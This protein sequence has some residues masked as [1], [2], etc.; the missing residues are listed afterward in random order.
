M[1]VTPRPTRFV[2]QMDLY[3]HACAPDRRTIFL[4]S[5]HAHRVVFSGSVSRQGDSHVGLVD[6]LGHVHRPLHSCFPIRIRNHDVRRCLSAVI[7]QTLIIK[8]KDQRLVPRLRVPRQLGTRRCLL[9]VIGDEAGVLP[10]SPGPAPVQHLQRDHIRPAVGHV[11]RNVHHQRRCIDAVDRVVAIGIDALAVAI[12]RAR[13]VHAAKHQPGPPPIPRCGNLDH[14][15]VPRIAVHIGKPLILP[16]LPRHHDAPTRIVTPRRV[17]LFRLALVL[18]IHLKPPTLAQIDRP[19]RGRCASSRDHSDQ[20]YRRTQYPLAHDVSLSF[21][22]RHNNTAPLP[23]ATNT[24]NVRAPSVG[25]ASPVGRAY[26]RAVGTR[27]PMDTRTVYSTTRYCFVYGVRSGPVG[28]ACHKTVILRYPTAS[29][30][31]RYLDCGS[32]ATA[33]TPGGAGML[34]PLTTS[35]SPLRQSDLSVISPAFRNS[36]S[37]S[38]ILTE[39]LRRP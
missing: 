12:H 32:N 38:V 19:R 29:T 7:P 11:P 17:P 28:K 1:A 34:I 9:R 21:R 16:P 20:Q 6:L 24:G 31:G 22:P 26:P 15:P 10:Q 36:A 39:P 35:Q 4:N 5:R 30:I 27:E 14:A 3:G 2:R 8:L 25:R 33:F 23:A 13:I 18:R 37:P